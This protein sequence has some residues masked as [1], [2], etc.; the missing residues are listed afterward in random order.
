[1]NLPTIHG[2]LEDIT[3]VVLNLKQVRLRMD[4]DEPQRLTLRVDS[5][6]PGHGRADP[7]Q[8]AC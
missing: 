7:D 6:G 5:K 8:P 3:D 2:V 4:T 1:M